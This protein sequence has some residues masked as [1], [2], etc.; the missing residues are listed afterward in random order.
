MDDVQEISEN[1]WLSD[2]QSEVYKKYYLEGKSDSEV[3]DELGVDPG[4]VRGY[5]HRIRKKVQKSERLLEL[6]EEVD[7]KQ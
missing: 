1:T 3:A 6:F 4:T 2:Q 7:I 5:L